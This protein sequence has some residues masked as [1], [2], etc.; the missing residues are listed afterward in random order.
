MR[1]TFH[2]RG[3]SDT[4]VVVGLDMRDAEDLYRRIM[5]EVPEN[6]IGYNVKLVRVDDYRAVEGMRCH[7]FFM[8]KRSREAEGAHEMFAL[9]DSNVLAS[10][11]RNPHWKRKTIAFS[12]R[13]K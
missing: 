6:L 8:S 12:A 3:Y 4:A 11:C 1:Y 13:V 9:L 7:D 5:A 10:R 2:H